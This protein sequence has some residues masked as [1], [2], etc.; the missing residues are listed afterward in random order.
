MTALLVTSCTC[1]MTFCGGRLALRLGDSPAFIFAFAGGALVTSARIEVIPDALEMIT[2]SGSSM[3]QHHL[4]LACSL[5]FLSFYLLEEFAHSGGL[6]HGLTPAATAHPGLWGAAHAGLWGATGISVHSL[7]DGVAI[8]EAFQAGA[9][10]GWIVS[11]AVIVHKFADGVSTVGILVST[12]RSRRVA[13][14][15]LIV[16][17]LAPLAGLVLQAVVPLPLSLLALLLGW[18][19]GVFLYLGAA[20]LMPAGRAASQSRWLPAATLLGAALVYL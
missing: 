11:M 1:V 18:F 8:G 14:R 5:G 3:R 7:L 2:R 19:S 12:G 20:A 17:A 13:N 4:M 6:R 9:G 10:I 16:T 15:M